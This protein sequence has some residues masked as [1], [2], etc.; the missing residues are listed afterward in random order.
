MIANEF[1]NFL[2]IKIKPRDDNMIDQYSRIFMVKMFLLSSII[3]GLNW[4][5]DKFNCILPGTVYGVIVFN[6]VRSGADE[7]LF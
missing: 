6:I 3:C 4:Y 5:F 2:T 7:C 1:K